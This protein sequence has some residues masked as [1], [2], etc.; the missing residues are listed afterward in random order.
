VKTLKITFLL[1]AL[2]VA[3]NNATSQNIN[4]IA[5]IGTAGFSG[6]AGAAI[7]AQL[8]GPQDVALDTFGNV[9]IADAENHRIRKITATTGVITTIA[10]TG[11]FG[12]SGDGGPA[13]SAKFYSPIGIGL[14]RAGNIYVADVGN[15]CI[16]KITASTGLITTVAGT[17]TAG[18]SGDGSLATSA[19]L[20]APYDVA[21]D[22]SGNLFIADV[23]NNCIRK[24]KASTGVISTV[25]GTT[26]PGFS[27]DGGAATLA[28]LYQPFSVIVD[29]SGN[30]Y[31]ADASNNRI[32]K[33]TASTGTITTIA[34]TGTAGYSGDGGAATAA[35]FN[36]P[37]SIGL[38]L[39]GNI[40]ISDFGNHRVRKITISTGII[41]TIAGTGVFGFSGDGGLAVSAQLY[42]PKGIYVDKVNNVFIADELNNRVRFI[43]NA[44]TIP[45]APLV[46]SPVTLCTS[47]TPVPLTAIGSNLKWYTTSTGGIGTPTAPT[48]SVSTIGTTTYYVSQSSACG[49]SPRAAIVVNVVAAPTV[50]A[51][52]SPVIYCSGVAASPLNASGSATLFWYTVATG[53]TATTITPTPSTATVGTTVYYVS[54]GVVGCESPRIPISVTINPTPASPIVSDIRYCI[55][56]T[57]SV[58]TASGTNLKW[59]STPSGGTA[60]LIAP[61]PSTAVD[62]TVAYY[63]TQTNS[64]NCES[65]RAKLNVSTN[66]KPRVSITAATAPKFFVCKGSKLTLKTIVAPYGIG[67]Q[68]QL[69]LLDITGANADSLQVTDAGLYRVL[70]SNAPNCNDTATVLVSID[71]SFTKTSIAPT[72]VNICDGVN[73]KLFSSSSLGVGYKYEWIKD[74]VMLNDTDATIVVNR[75]GVYELKVTNP[76]GCAVVSNA[77]SVNTFTPIIK[78][79]INQIGNTLLVP[80]IYSSYQ[81][82]RNNKIISGA[83]ASNYSL[84]FDGIYFV[85][86]SDINGC[87]KESDTL[88]IINLSVKEVAGDKAY[89]VFPNPTSEAIFV[90]SSTPVQLILSDLLGRTISIPRQDSKLELT[91]LPSGVYF[92]QIFDQKGN[93]LGVEKVIKTLEQ[94]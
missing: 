76:L 33:V 17:G 77:S 62:G 13:T 60:S 26:S 15:N 37:Y 39:S 32:R 75:K 24:V 64:F 38:D 52:T 6:D 11:T 68:W 40:Y 10:G 59:Y 94:R 16:R 69:G 30:L 34:G 4:T 91:E 21:V 73:V 47:S 28:K 57:P 9:Y 27:G 2:L 58:L 66:T 36:K 44:A 72:D 74:G 80:S 29:G 55:A 56:A 25:A 48:P 43:C 46:S 90:T 19:R 50:P 53:G 42:N 12:Y 78:P 14:D 70:V 93:K 87:K 67:Y 8:Y 89:S 65:S 41:S 86:V 49:E 71:S 81:W 61:T 18:Y 92:L 88:S 51:A 20:Y 79:S 23:S 1:L 7:L 85:E 31:I 63:V 5:G 82:Y 3:S 22:D 84:S 35:K 83:N 45:A 54:Q